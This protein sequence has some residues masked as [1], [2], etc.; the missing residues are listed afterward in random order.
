MILV[1]GG[2]GFV[3][4]H[5]LRRL[6]AEGKPVR[7]LVRNVKAAVLPAGVDVV[8]G[9]LTRPDTVRA[10]L[11]G[12]DVLIHA[13]ALTGDRKE[14]YR[15]AYD[16]VNCVGT[17][18]L[19]AGAKRA[20]VGKIVLVS[21]LGT[22]PAR[23]GSYMSTRW[24]ME[25]AVRRSGIPH[26][27]LQPSV[28]FGAGA[29]FV[30]G[31]AKV[32]KV[33]P[34]A[35]AIGWELKFQPLWIEDLSRCVAAAA[36]TEG[37]N[38]QE[39][40]LG[41]AEQ[42]SMRG[43]VAIIARSLG[44]RPV[45]VPVPVFAARLQARLM[46][47]ILSQPPLTPAAAE[48]FSFDNIAA[49]DSV[50][51][52]FGFKPHGFQRHVLTHGLELEP[53]VAAM[54]PASAIATSNPRRGHEPV[55]AEGVGVSPQL[56]QLGAGA[57]AARVEPPA[58]QKGPVTDGST[59]ASA[60]AAGGERRS[61]E[62]TTVRGGEEPPAAADRKASEPGRAAHVTAAPPAEPSAPANA[63][64]G[65]VKVAP[66]G[67]GQTNRRRRRAGTKTDPSGTPRTKPSGTDTGSA[68]A[69][70]GVQRKASKGGA[71]AAARDSDSIAVSESIKAPAEGTEGG[72]AATEAGAPVRAKGRPDD[73]AR[74]AR[75]RRSRAAP[76]GRK[77]RVD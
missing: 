50:E 18:R 67:T 59:S 49:L 1:T 4:G 12:V 55:A 42:I 60:M 14:P 19:V 28:L 5:V 31:L 51:A 34:V 17:E 27:I 8:E 72:D 40:P 53:A 35:P 23:P 58:L 44:K 36:E 45:V 16:Q 41:G 9:D 61:R 10:A 47:R 56:S 65:T 70:G 33:S 2:T 29:A 62:L 32:V 22:K 48:L 24:A 64:K 3:G 13:A 54:G 38:G 69:V 25:E 57:P 7:A 15:G 37:L 20:G 73:P 46:N 26:V 66:A 74:P 6:A 39:L 52:A 77:P 30:R 76:P 71:G 63:P 68:P 75:K 43:L 11:T 21:G